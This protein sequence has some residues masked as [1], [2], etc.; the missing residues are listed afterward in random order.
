MKKI[1]LI[2]STLVLALV[3]AFTG[4][5]S[6]EPTVAAEKA[7]VAKAAKAKPV[8]PADAVDIEKQGFLTVESCSTVGAFQDC[9]LEN[10]MCG[11]EG[12][13]KE[14][15]PGVFGEVQIV[16]FVHNEGHTYNIDI[17]NINATDIDKGINRNEV[18]II[19]KYDAANNII[20]ATEFK[21]PPPPKKSFFKGCL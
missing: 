5:G 1:N 20:F 18:T 3:L 12:C 15:E 13:F 7:P 14:F 21:S 4:C 8:M 17:S 9:R 11:S 6:I 16:L 2:S 10:Y 19:G